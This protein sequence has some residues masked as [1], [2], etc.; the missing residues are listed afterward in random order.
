MN[1]NVPGLRITLETI[2]ST[3]LFTRRRR[4]FRELRRLDVG[5]RAAL[6]SPLRRPSMLDRVR[7]LVILFDGLASAERQRVVDHLR[8]QISESHE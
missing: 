2:E 8:R 7:G 5:P 4:R 1:R 6:V 3:R